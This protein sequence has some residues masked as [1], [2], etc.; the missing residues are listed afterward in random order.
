MTAVSSP[1]RPRIANVSLSRAAR[2]LRLARLLLPASVALW[3]YGVART[4]ISHLG[5]L[6]LMT[7][8]PVVFYAG[9]ALVIISASVELSR[10]RLSKVW[11]AAHSVAL[12]VMLYG[13]APLI[14]PEPR[15]SWLYRHI[16]IT[17]YVNAHGTLSRSIDIYQNW[18]G[19]FAMAGWFDKVAGVSSPLAY[20]KWAQLIFELAILP[21]LYLAYRALALPLRQRWIA[22]LLYSASN[23]IAQDY[24]SPQALGSILG[25]GLV[26][27]ALRWTFAGNST[28]PGPHQGRRSL[29]DHKSRLDRRWRIE[30]RPSWLRSHLRWRPK[31]LP[32][33][34]PFSILV[35][36]IYSVL[37]FTHELSPYIVLVQ[38]GT[39]AV[40]GLTRP[41]W[42][43]VVLAAVCFGYLLP[44]F[45]FVNQNFGIIATIGDFFG[46][47]APPSAGQLP[48]PAA[49]SF[50]EHAAQALSLG[51]W[52]L[53]LVGAW[54]RRKSR[55]TV[56]ALC[57]LMI[58]PVVVLAAG[59]Y[60]NEGIL[61]VYLFSLPWAAALAAAAIS[62]T[63]HL[64][65]DHKP[66]PAGTPS[67]SNRRTW[68]PRVAWRAPLAFGAATA[69]FLPAFFGDD[70]QN[71]MTVPEVSTITAFY[72]A[73][74][75]GLLFLPDVDI[76]GWDT[77]NY[78]KWSFTQI[79]GPG[80]LWPRGRANLGIAGLIARSAQEQNNGRQPAYVI[81]TANVVD[82]N[83]ANPVTQAGNIGTLQQ[84]L[85]RS[86]YW[87]LV[88]NRDGTVIYELPPR[89]TVPSGPRAAVNGSVP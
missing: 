43:P 81:L 53:A 58:S 33:W 15:Y 85:A 10:Q 12:V 34:L 65:L 23:W 83:D 78:N 49:E 6:G 24:F 45:A 89:A 70:A 64:A 35:V 7:A 71:V 60:A 72:N 37:T 46:N 84:S 51:I 57:L 86:G 9:L 25:L 67:T 75:P 74:P 87:Q 54:L 5:L 36:L 55:R 14:Y 62:A 61:R 40:F 77:A 88:L 50:I 42:L 47:I 20:A 56:R 1:A 39:L 11:L 80:T 17:Q 52:V 4:N 13:T 18:P 32:T 28:G 44:R 31:D 66:D 68:L 41:R 76:P 3:A 19:F 16:G 27:I 38:L 22:I 82:Y 21:L 48:V 59:G 8:L 63:P 79:F 30:H 26:A 2:D 29:A 69:L 73:A